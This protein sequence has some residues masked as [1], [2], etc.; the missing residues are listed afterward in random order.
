MLHQFGNLCYQMEKI[1]EMGG[2]LGKT[3]WGKMSWGELNVLGEMS[4]GGKCEWKMSG[5]I[6]GGGAVGG[7]GGERNVGI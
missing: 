1:C 7:G 5:E 6:A 2:C 3:V 4:G